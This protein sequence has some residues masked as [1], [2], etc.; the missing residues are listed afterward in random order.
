[1]RA[2]RANVVSILSKVQETVS[3]L[4]RLKSESQVMRVK[5]ADVLQ[6]SSVVPHC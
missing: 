2:I 4:P 3:A 1:M 5:M 6:R